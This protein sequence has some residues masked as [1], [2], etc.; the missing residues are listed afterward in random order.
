MKRQLCCLS[1]FFAFAASAATPPP[2]KV[3]AG[4]TVAVFTV[5]DY[6]KASA[7][8]KQ[9]PASLLWADPA[10]KPFKD[11]FVNKLRSDLLA[12]LEKEKPKRL[13]RF[14]LLHLCTGR[15]VY[16]E[17]QGPGFHRGAK[18]CRPRQT[19]GS[20]SGARHDRQG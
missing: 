1:L 15:R 20:H 10:M 5:P 12:P 16:P 4:D 2:E 13:R 14:R 17:Q 9:W 7:A 18:P 11:K 8:W 3:L 19:P 6:A